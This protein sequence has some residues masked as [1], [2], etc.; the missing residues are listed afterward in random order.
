MTALQSNPSTPSKAPFR[1]SPFRRPNSPLGR[2]PSTIRAPTPQGSPLKQSTPSEAIDAGHGYVRNAASD[3][4]WIK[5]SQ[6]TETVPT[7]SKSPIPFKLTSTLPENREDP[8]PRP[9]AVRN[10]ASIN[11]VNVDPLSSVPPHYLHTMRESFS[12][13][14]RA[15]TGQIT[16]S[17][18]SNTLAELG[19]ENSASTMSTYFPSASSSLNLGAYLNLL[20]RD[21]T[22]LNRQDELMAAFLAFDNDDSDQIDI[23]ELKDALMTTAPE[24]GSPLTEREIEEVMEGFVGRRVLKKGQ[25]NSNLGGKKEVFRYAD[26]TSSIWGT[27]G[28]GS[29]NGST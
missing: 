12:V 22:R 8:V 23:A 15:N 29:Q 11:R 18:V 24:S 21:L 2:S 27:V 5:Q 3:K 16:K 25:I 28:N 17:D 13:L 26:F 4:A 19:L 7:P 14:D 20:A 10:E 1:P 9:L 6:D